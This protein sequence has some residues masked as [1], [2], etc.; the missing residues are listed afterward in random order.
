MAGTHHMLLSVI[1][2]VYN[3]KGYLK[4]CLESVTSQG[5]PEDSYE[6]ITA[7]STI[8]LCYT[9]HSFTFSIYGCLGNITLKQYFITASV[10]VFLCT[11]IYLICGVLGYLLYSDE[12]KDTILDGIGNDALNS[13]DFLSIYQLITIFIYSV[14]SKFSHLRSTPVGAKQTSPGCLAP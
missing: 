4:G 6:I 3:L 5:L 13:S 9:Y 1:I 11:F 10:T 12:I 14:S 7:V 8:I 2:P